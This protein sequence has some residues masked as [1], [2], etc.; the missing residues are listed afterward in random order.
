[1]YHFRTYPTVQTSVIEECLASD[2]SD[3]SAVSGV[4]IKHD[5]PIQVDLPVEIPETDE[6]MKTLQ[7]QEDRITI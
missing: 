1:M 6:T 2:T 4:K 3:T 5:T 7:E